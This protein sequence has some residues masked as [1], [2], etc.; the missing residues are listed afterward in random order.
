MTKEEA[1]TLAFAAFKRN[2]YTKNISYKFSPTYNLEE[3]AILR[4]G[5]GSPA[6]NVWMTLQAQRKVGVQIQVSKEVSDDLLSSDFG[7]ESRM[8]DIPWPAPV[9]ELYF[10]D[11]LLPTV[12]VMK[13]HPKAIEGWFPGL[14]SM[15]EGDEIMTCV[16]QTSLGLESCFVSLIIKPSMYKEFL[17]DVD[18]DPMA[19]V[20]TGLYNVALDDTDNAAMNVMAR[21]ALKVFAFISIPFLKPQPLSRKQMRFGG[22]AGV[23]GR[24]QRPSFRA[25]YLPH[26][27]YENE[28]RVEEPTGKH[29]QFK[30]RRGHFRYYK[31]EV[32]KNKRGTWTMIRPVPGPDGKVPKRTLLKVRKPNI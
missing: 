20:G 1:E 4:E 23:C 10:E 15:I 13:T 3:F 11:P 17:D 27:R 2:H 31:S 14:H 7:V 21:L 16:M 9:C 32:F 19:D 18:V 5:G 29:I 12:V 28:V 8:Q 22:K 25:I 6:Q 24:P 26:A 30:G